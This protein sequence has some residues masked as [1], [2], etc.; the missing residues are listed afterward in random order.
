MERLSRAIAGEGLDR[1]PVALWRR[2][3]GDDQRAGDF[4]AS[5]VAFQR[6]YAWDMLNIYPAD[7]TLTLDYGGQEAWQGDNDGANA[8]VKRAVSKSLEWTMLRPLDSGRG[9]L[10]RLVETI[11]LCSEGLRDDT[12]LIVTLPS[13]LMQAQRLAGEGALRL[14]MR[15]QPDRVHS[16]LNTLT[17][18]TL[19]IIDALRRSG[20]NGIG[21]TV[22]HASAG[23]LSEDEYRLF[24]LPYDRRIFEG[25]PQSWWLTMLNFA[26][27][28]PY[29]RIAA[30]LRPSVVCWRDQEGDPDL[31]Q[32]KLLAAGAVCGGWDAGAHL[33][34]GTPVVIRDAARAAM[35][36]TGERRLI[37]SAGMPVPVTT[38]LANLR[39]ARQSVERG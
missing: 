26:S 13:P 10:G 36:R 27:P 33:H 4:A 16:G 5:L 12:P 35:Q 15:T 8:V 32:G 19:R 31:V 37:L 9:A 22:L 34:Y 24:G 20:L 3:P 23:Q 18:T 7:G 39:A 14:H 30:E 6:E 17:E 1:L 38:P 25:L 21:Y 11:G 2:F 28:T 29:F